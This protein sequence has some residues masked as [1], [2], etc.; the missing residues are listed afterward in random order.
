ME[1]FPSRYGSRQYYLE[2]VRARLNELYKGVKPG[3]PGHRELIDLEE[4]YQ[5]LLAKND[6]I[7][8]II[9]ATNYIKLDQLIGFSKC[10][11]G[12][13]YEH[14]SINMIIKDLIKTIDPNNETQIDLFNRIRLDLLQKALKFYSENLG[15]VTGYNNREINK[16]ILPLACSSNKRRG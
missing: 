15:L 9:V 6:E 11:T 4:R 1:N 3:S 14:E 8:A 10:Y 16:I 7:V 5:A 2:L 12:N 13:A